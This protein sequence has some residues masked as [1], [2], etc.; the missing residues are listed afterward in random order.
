MYYIYRSKALVFLDNLNRVIEETGVSAF[1]DCYQINNTTGQDV[2]LGVL[3]FSQISQLTSLTG[4]GTIYLPYD[5]DVN[6][7]ASITEVPHHRAVA[8]SGKAK[9]DGAIV[10]GGIGSLD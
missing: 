2:S 4:G 1:T 9:T 5:Q 6:P 10:P 7:V 3:V 8:G